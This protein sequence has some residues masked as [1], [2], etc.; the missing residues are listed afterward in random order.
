MSKRI[1][2]GMFVFAVSSILAYTSSSVALSIIAV[3]TMFYMVCCDTTSIV[4]LL[5]ATSFVDIIVLPLG[6]MSMTNGRIVVMVFLVLWVLSKE[7]KIERNNL[8]FA[9]ALISSVLC[10]MVL[11]NSEIGT[12]ISW[13][14]NILIFIAISSSNKLMSKAE[15]S[16][17]VACVYFFV[18]LTIVFYLLHFRAIQLNAYVNR[19]TIFSNVNYNV[20]AIT[21][22]F[23]GIIIISRTL[24]KGNARSKIIAVIALILSVLSIFKTG[25]RTSLLAVLIGTY[26]SYIL[27]GNRNRKIV[28]FLTITLVASVLG[29]L[30]APS[31]MG[32]RFSIN[33]IATDGGSGRFSSYPILLTQVLPQ[34][35]LT[36]VGVGGQYSALE[37][38]NLASFSPAHNYFLSCILEMGIILGPI[39]IAYTF[40]WV[41]TAIDLY[42]FDKKY[43]FLV[44]II[45]SLLLVGLGET[46]YSER[47]T[48]LFAAIISNLF[49]IQQVFTQIDEE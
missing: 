26:I 43:V 32:T 19:Y 4:A 29:I 14:L 44:T 9:M 38:L 46:V 18:Y 47:Y 41:K 45:L 39:F 28:R 27:S 33:A 6:S 20:L 25:S 2:F 3:I 13:I 22:A 31:L 11:G 42:R 40:S 15:E 12:I 1:Y 34:Y 16:F 17:D 10:S 5:I 30:I 23:S 35:L 48:I 24:S 36:G 7:F 21:I 8:Y 37:A 49:R